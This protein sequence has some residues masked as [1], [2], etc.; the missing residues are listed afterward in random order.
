MNIP[1]EI[2]ATVFLSTFGFIF[3]ALWGHHGAIK[4][5]VK[6]SD[7]KHNRETCPCVRELEEIKDK[8]EK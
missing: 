8:L 1:I 5:R 2:I 3:G 4:D 7:C 6:Y